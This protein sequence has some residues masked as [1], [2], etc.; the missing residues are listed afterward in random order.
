[1]AVTTAEAVAELPKPACDIQP[2]APG[3][4]GIP[5]KPREEPPLCGQPLP[6]RA[7]VDRLQQPRHTGMVTF[8]VKFVSV[9]AGNSFDVLLTM[10]CDLFACHLR[11]LHRVPARSEQAR[12]DFDLSESKGD[13]I[14]RRFLIQ[15]LC[16]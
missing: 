9:P 3:S 15:D 6:G 11:S 14:G 1:V 2:I 4:Q 8:Q 13:S 10:I 7:I 12:A 16:W 5:V